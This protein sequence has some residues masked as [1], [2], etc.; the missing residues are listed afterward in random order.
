MKATPKCWISINAALTALAIVGATAATATPKSAAPT[1]PAAVDA[2]ASA[3]PPTTATRVFL[4]IDS[5][6]SMAQRIGKETRIDH[7]LAVGERHV[8]ALEVPSFIT[9]E[10]LTASD[11]VDVVGSFAL[12]SEGDRT[13]LLKAIRRIQP[14]RETRTVFGAIDAGLADVVRRDTGSGETFGIVLLTDAIA[15]DPKTDLRADEIGDRLIDVRGGVVAVV[16]GAVPRADALARRG[17]PIRRVTSRS[18]VGGTQPSAVRALYSGV[19]RIVGEATVTGVVAPGLFGGL[20]PVRSELRVDNDVGIARLVRFDSVAPTGT[21]VSFSPNPLLVPAAGSA[22]V[23][24]EL[25][26]PSVVQGQAVVI[27]R[28][29]DGRSQQHPID[30]HLTPRRWG[31]SHF[32]LIALVT[33][34]AVVACAVIF[35]RIRRTERIGEHSDTDRQAALAIGDSVPLSTFS[36]DVTGVLTRG[37]LR[38]AIIADGVPVSVSGRLVQPGK[39]GRY[40]LGEDIRVGSRTFAIYR[41]IDSGTPA[42]GAGFSFDSPRAGWS[43]GGLR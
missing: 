14:V 15:D 43:T 36:P 39:R 13:A 16:L 12:R 19:I 10:L 35:W 40:R 2:H 24:V 26:A 29:P 17:T 18:R 28:L 22:T 31:M 34:A 20:R 42:G 6:G 21:V 5:S 38:Y 9:V 25:S 3:V 11:R 8:A 7:A 30:V 4:V 23:T 41:I 1:I 37:W 27:A 32:W 33:V